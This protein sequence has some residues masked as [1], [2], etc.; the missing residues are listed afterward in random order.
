[1][2]RLCPGVLVISLVL[3]NAVLAQAPPVPVD[4]EVTASLPVPLSQARQREIKASIA[5]SERGLTSA[6]PRATDEFP[7]GRTVPPSVDLIA[8]PEDAIGEVPTTSSYR[9]VLMRE[10]IAVVDPAT[11]LVVQVIK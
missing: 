6:L 5:N 11:R 2:Q 3:A 7:V 8:L 9:F 4:V 1:M 10:G